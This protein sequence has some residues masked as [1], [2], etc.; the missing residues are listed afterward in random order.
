MSFAKEMAILGVSAE[1]AAA[2]SDDSLRQV[3]A[4]VN[5]G[6]LAKESVVAALADIAKTG[7]LDLSKFAVMTDT[8]LEKELKAIVAANKSLPFNALIG[9]AMERLRGKAPGQKIVEKLKILA[10]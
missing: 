9:K 5:S 1:A 7:K 10:K 8:E 4:A 2:V 6:K 3:F